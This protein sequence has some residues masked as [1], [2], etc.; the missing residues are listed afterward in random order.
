[1]LSIHHSWVPVAGISISQY[2]CA[3]LF[4]PFGHRS[5][6]SAHTTLVHSTGMGNPVG[7]QVW[8]RRVW[9]RVRCSSPAPNPYLPGRYG[10]YW[11][12]QWH[13]WFFF[14]LPLSPPSPLSY[15]LD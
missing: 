7:M 5:S 12:G 9:V 10:G 15:L 13:V 4:Q 3:S 8:V 6:I 14:V 1:M 2:T 11:T